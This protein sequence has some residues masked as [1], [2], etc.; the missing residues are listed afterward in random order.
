[1]GGSS[2]VIGSAMALVL[3]VSTAGQIDG[4]D[5][6]DTL[7]GL[8]ASDQAA[9]LGI[10]LEGA[11]ELLRYTIMV[12]GVLSVASVVLGVYVLR[13]HRG[14]RVALTVIG[15]LVAAASLAA[16]PAGWLITLY[17]GA[18]VF[19]VW[20]RPARAWFAAGTGSGDGSSSGPPAGP[21]S[22]SPNGSP[23]GPGSPHDPP[24][25]PRRG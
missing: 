25:G 2:A 20:T 11:R 23:S 3:L 9:T 4:Q 12:M 19:L 13:R 21:P 16:G 10:S 18:S 14:S 15:G 7:T 8:V 1:M 24:Q 6:T 17:I 22:E 5:M